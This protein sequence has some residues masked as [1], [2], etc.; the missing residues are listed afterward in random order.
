MKNGCGETQLLVNT[1][2][3]AYLCHQSSKKLSPNPSQESRSVRFINL[4]IYQHCTETDV[5]LYHQSANRYVH[6]V[7]IKPS[8]N[9]L[10]ISCLVANSH[11]CDC[12]SGSC[13]QPTVFVMGQTV[14]NVPCRP[15]SCR[16]TQNPVVQCE[17][18]SECIF[19][20]PYVGEEYADDWTAS[21]K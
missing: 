10:V 17:K 1:R 9:K 5:V 16:S 12:I 3:P 21:G 7:D 8:R 2:F 19:A 18:K 6:Y 14:K 4:S 15:E 11:T 13:M 20:Y